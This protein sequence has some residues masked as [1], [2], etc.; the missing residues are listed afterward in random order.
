MRNV[1]AGLLVLAVVAPFEVAAQEAPLPPADWGALPP[2]SLVEP[3]PLAPVDSL[4]LPPAPADFGAP[5][6]PAPATDESAATRSPVLPGTSPA[7]G[8]FDAGA[9]FGAPPPP[10]AAPADFGAPPAPVTDFGAPPPAAD[11]G[12]PPAPVAD[13]A[14][15]PPAPPPAFG[16]LPPAPGAAP[17]GS[18]P[19]GTVTA[20][21]TP[22]ADAHSPATGD[23][24]VDDPRTTR[25]ASSPFGPVGLAR[26][27]AAEPGPL[28]TFRIGLHGR[29][30]DSPGFPVVETQNQLVGGTWT[31]AWTPLPYLDLYG[32]YTLLS[33]RN[34]QGSPPLIQSQGDTW[35]GAKAG[36]EASEGLWLGADLR[37][38]FF[39]AIGDQRPAAAGFQ[40]TALLTYDVH[41]V[42]PSVPLRLHLNVGGRIDGTRDLVA[43]RLTPAE[44]FALDVN[45]YNRLALAAGVEVPLPYVTPFAEFGTEFL[46]GAPAEL[47]QTDGAW[48]PASDAAPRRLTFG[49]RVTAVEDLSFLVAS[50]VGLQR[51]VVAGVPATPPW[52]LYFGVA[53]TFAPGREDRVQVVERV[54]EVPAPVAAAVQTVTGKVA[55]VVLDATTREPIPGAVVALATSSAPGLPPVATDAGGGRF[56]SHELPP[57]PVD[58]TVTKDG[59]GAASV[60]LVVQAGHETPAEIL[61]TPEAPAPASLI[62]RVRGP[63]GPIDAQ[64]TADGPQNA[65][66][67]LVNGEGQAELPP[68]RYRVKVSARGFLSREGTAEVTGSAPTT[69]QF[70]LAPKPKTTGLVFSGKKILPKRTI[71]FRGDS[72]EILP[73][74]FRYLDEVAAAMIDNDY[75]RLRIDAHVSNAYGDRAGAVTRARAEAVRDYLVDKAGLDAGKLVL[76]AWGDSAPIA[77]NITELGRK[78]NTR[79]TF[80][81]LDR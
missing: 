19:A 69:V 21:V 76:K 39:P 17:A 29:F 14:T 79:V 3:A 34:D 13:F 42:S 56:V 4:G 45:E 64:V 70:E 75:R 38:A 27:T 59:Y 61:L 81:I 32:A 58:L 41:R 18:A 22:P 44:T 51:H 2:P 63:R 57:G 43:E 33:N 7:F 72:A 11:F 53:Y 15:A 46:L 60:S 78:M 55:G 28:G 25:L 77:P 52:Q 36:F 26:V 50:D 40:P 12:T 49:A 9:D 24:S 8:G 20:S 67:S 23:F 16:A 54:V 80:T 66:I 68:G 1:L 35:L 62:V 74:S 5:P 71:R 30:F 37:L 31:V 10:A 48:V 6:P 73:S 47:E 65:R